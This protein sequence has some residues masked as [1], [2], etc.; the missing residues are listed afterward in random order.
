MP[1]NSKTAFE[2][3]KRRYHVR[4]WME[5]ERVDALK[6]LPDGRVDGVFA[7]E[8]LQ[9]QDQ[10]K[11]HYSV[12]RVRSTYRVADASVR[13]DVAVYDANANKKSVTDC[14]VAQQRNERNGLRLIGVMRRTSGGD[15]G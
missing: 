3:T 10:R 13:I 4:T 8:D 2:S 12:M 1:R 6:D 9:R 14:G 15:D 5:E 11:L 7:V